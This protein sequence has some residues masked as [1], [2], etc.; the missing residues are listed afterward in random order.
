MA[1]RDE[2]ER[3]D[4]IVGWNSILHDQP[5][6]NARLARAGERPVRLGEKFGTW[7]W[8][9]MYHAGGQSMKIG[10]RRLETVSKFFHT[11]VSKTPLEG[12]TW[13]LAGA[14]DRAAMD[15]VVEHCEADV[16]VLRALFPHLAPHVKKFTFSFSEVWPFI[17]EIPSR[18]VAA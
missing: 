17:G 16:L 4:L 9:A 12:E 6:L 5:L 2:L 14:G 15:Q 10:G 7:H 13:Q 18:K 11:D 8:D 1:I 3:A